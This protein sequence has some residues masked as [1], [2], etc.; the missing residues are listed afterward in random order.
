MKTQTNETRQHILDTGYELIVVKGFTSVGLS[1][2]LKHAQVPKGSF[3]HY[4]QSKEQF[5]E[6][7]IADYFDKYLQRL[8]SLFSDESLTHTERVMSYWQRWIENNQGVCGAERCLVVKL[9]SEVSD[10][11]EPMRLALNSG[12]NRVIAAIANCL[13]QGK[14]SGSIQVDNCQDTAVTLYQLWL[15]ASV[16]YKLSRDVSGMQNTLDKTADILQGKLAF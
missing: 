8:E 3:Y 10:L 13:E 4:F 9:S 5:G 11:S 7:L 2:L 6:A 12:A 14:Q 15:G 16:L 1:Q